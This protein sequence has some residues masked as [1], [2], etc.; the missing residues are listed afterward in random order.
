[1]ST[2]PPLLLS[3]CSRWSCLNRLCL[4]HRACIPRHVSYE[5]SVYFITCSDV[6]HDVLIIHPVHIVVKT[7]KD[8]CHIW[9]TL[10]MWNTSKL[11]CDRRSVGQSVLVSSTHMGPRTRFLLLSVAGLLMWGA[12]SDERTGRLQLLLARASIAILGSEPHGT[13]DHVLLSQ[14]GDSPNLEGQVPVFINPQEQGGPV[15]PPGTGF[16]FCHLLRLAGLQWRYWNPS[17]HR[18]WNSANGETKFE[19]CNKP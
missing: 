14:I 1:L 6:F 12:L 16:P 19:H 7:M 2:S 4:K 10:L 5:R 8:I 15:I 9:N 17:P 3:R 18:R 11:Y 13:H